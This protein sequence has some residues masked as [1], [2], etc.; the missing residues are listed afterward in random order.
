MEK[1][2]KNDSF[3]YGLYCSMAIFGLLADSNA[4]VNPFRKLSSERNRFRKRYTTLLF[5][6]K[7]CS[8]RLCLTTSSTGQ[9]S[10]GTKR[11]CNE[12]KEL[13]P[14][15]ITLFGSVVTI[16]AE[17]HCFST[18]CSDRS[19]AILYCNRVQPLSHEIRLSIKPS[20]AN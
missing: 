10:V 8:D 12:E 3:R 9:G 6:E 2:S 7:S 14:R 18:L 19:H 15:L 5:P 16:L 4:W 11:M 1:L 17:V 13:L 20:T